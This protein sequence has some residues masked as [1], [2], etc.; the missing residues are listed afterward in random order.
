MPDLS[1]L[2]PI[3]AQS[4][5]SVLISKVQLFDSVEKIKYG[6]MPFSC[7]WDWVRGVTWRRLPEPCSP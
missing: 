3:I 6:K 7:Q 5:R 2:Q 1:S 4:V